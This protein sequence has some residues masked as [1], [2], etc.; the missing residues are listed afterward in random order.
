MEVNSSFYFWLKE[1]A[2]VGA[3]AKQ[4]Q[5]QF[6]SGLLHDLKY[7]YLALIYSVVVVVF[8]VLKYIYF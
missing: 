2:V 1:C 3:V 7:F 6:K 8:L 5:I 4:Q